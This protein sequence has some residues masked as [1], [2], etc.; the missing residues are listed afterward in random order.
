MANN[1]LQFSEHLELP[2]G[3]EA[4]SEKVLS[5]LKMLNDELYDEMETDSNEDVEAY[6]SDEDKE[7]LPDGFYVQA[8]TDEKGVWFYS[9]ESGDLEAVFYTAQ[10][11]LKEFDIKEPFVVSWAYTCSKPRISEFGGGAAAIYQ[12]NIISID[13]REHIEKLVNSKK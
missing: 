8:E 13:A 2:K 4:R 11:L 12:D 7:A 6:P 1:Y 5:R 9:E 3:H 10:L